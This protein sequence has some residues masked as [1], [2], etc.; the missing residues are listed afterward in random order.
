MKKGT[1]QSSMWGLVLAAGKG[2]RMTE[3]THLL[4]GRP[5]PKQFA[6]L[7]SE[8]TLLQETLDRM[9]PL[10]PPERTVVVV[11]EG[12]EELARMQLADKPGV[13]IISQP[14]DLG[15]GPG[16][17]LPLTHVLARDPQATVAVFPS[18]HHFERAEPLRAALQPGGDRRRGD[19]IGGGVVGGARG[20]PG[21]RSR[22]DR[23]ARRTARRRQ[24]GEQVRREA[25]RA[26]RALAAGRRWSVEHHVD[27]RLGAIVLATVPRP[28]AQPDP[29][30][31]PLRRA[32]TV[33]RV[34]RAPRVALS[35]HSDGGLQPGGARAGRW[36]G[37]GPADQFGLVRLRHAGTADRMVAQDGDRH[38]VLPRL[39][40]MA[41][42]QAQLRAGLA[43]NR[44]VA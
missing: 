39:A 3:V 6:P 23:S 2:S 30:L 12:H 35:D 22:L 32:R 14:R 21:V 42:A 18:D 19:F 44:A 26:Y 29:G 25:A 24:P 9:A 8:R 17:L 16:L 41:Q 43:P 4:C 11:A 31:Q 36:S 27:G 38:G 28:S 10:I 20:S 5:L 33:P 13:E 1:S 34:R 40:P 7:V 15:T 37:G